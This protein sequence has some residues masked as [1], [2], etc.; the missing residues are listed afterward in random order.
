MIP[1]KDNI[2]MTGEEDPVKYYY[3]PIIRNFYLKRLK[4]ILRLI[5]ENKGGRVLDIG[6][7]S[8]ILFPELSKRFDE[9]Y[10]IDL[11]DRID[12]VKRMLKKEGISANLTTG[13]ILNLPYENEKFDCVTCVSILEHVQD[14]DRAISEITRVLRF[15]GIVVFGFPPLG[16]KMD[17]LFRLIGYSNS[18]QHHISGKTEIIAK[19]KEKLLIQ[20][21]ITFSSFL[22][23]LCTIYIACRCCKK[24]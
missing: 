17:F 21:M 7:G 13:N 4:M 1:P 24:R 20:N 11:H 23:K 14:L 18:S 15:E 2:Y 8:G 5:G 22:P 16:K 9:L 19:I 12:L 10:G 6:Y 3:R